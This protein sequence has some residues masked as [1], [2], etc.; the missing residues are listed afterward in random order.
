MGAWN[1]RYS[2]VSINITGNNMNYQSKGTIEHP[3][4]G[5]IRSGKELGHKARNLCI[6]HA[7]IGCGKERWVQ[8]RYIRAHRH[9]RC[10]QCACRTKEFRKHTSE[11]DRARHPT[12]EQAPR[13]NGGKVKRICLNCGREFTVKANLV[14]R[15]YG[16]FCSHSCRT[17]YSYKNGSFKRI[18]N[19]L[20]KSLIKL[21]RDNN[22][23]YRYT[24]DGQVWFGN[25]NPDFINV[26]GDKQVIECLGTYWHPM[27]DGAQR[28]EH[29]KQYG[30]STLTIWE[31]ELKDKVKLLGKIKKFTYQKTPTAEMRV[32]NE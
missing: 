22:L 12:G 6:Y 30:F 19:V 3:E 9:L 28:I 4:I 21:I 5:D 7:C 18:P 26:N 20:E 14:R 24:G 32:K 27:F 10:L 11:M 1:W 13:W 16:K 25:R 23:P 31:D 8:I 29:Y 2:N 15:G 17:I